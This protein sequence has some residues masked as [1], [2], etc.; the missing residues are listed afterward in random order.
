MVEKLG[1]STRRLET[2]AATRLSP[3]DAEQKKARLIAGPLQKK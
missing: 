3:F 1:G 2:R